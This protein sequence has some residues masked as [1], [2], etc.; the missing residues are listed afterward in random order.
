MAVLPTPSNYAAIWNLNPPSSTIPLQESA[1]A[2]GV[3]GPES[4]GVDRRTLV[5]YSDYA[6]GGE[7]R[8]IIK[9]FVCYERQPNDGNWGMATGWLIAPDLL[10]TAGHVAY[11]FGP[12]TQYGKAV[13]VKAYMGYTGAVNVTPTNLSRRNVQL[14][15]GATFITTT[16]WLQ[17]AGQAER[18][19]V[20][21][22]KL[23]G[24][25]TGNFRPFSYIDTP[26]SGVAVNIGVVGYP[27]DQQNSAGEAGAEMYQMIQSPVIRQSDNSVIG[28]HVFNEG[29]VNSA[30]DV[31]GRYG[32]MFGPFIRAF[33]EMD[34]PIG[35]ILNINVIKPLTAGPDTLNLTNIVNV[36]FSGG[37]T[38]SP[39]PGT[40][41]NGT[42]GSTTTPVTP[43]TPVV[44]VSPVLPVAPVVPGTTGTTG[45]TGSTSSTIAP[46]GGSTTTTSGTEGF[47]DVLKDIVK[48]SLPVIDTG[49]R[50][51]FPSVGPL[52]PCAAA[53]GG[54][55]LGAICEACESAFNSST[56][57]FQPASA[58]TA[59]SLNGCAQRAILAETAL[60][61]AFRLDSRE[62]QGQQIITDMANIY[63]TVQ[64]LEDLNMKLF[65]AI[66]GPIL[67]IALN[68]ITATPPTQ[69]AT[70]VK[71]PL[72]G[73]AAVESSFSS[74]INTSFAT[75]L[76]QP[77]I[78]VPGQESF[79]DNLSS[80]I[81]TGLQ[82]AT[83]ITT[84]LA[85]SAVKSALS[86]SPESAL[87]ATARDN[88]VSL[89]LFRRAI[90]AECALQAVQ[91]IDTTTLASLPLYDEQGNP[92]TEGF[93]D[94]MTKA[95]QTIGQKVLDA[96]PD[97]I[98]SVGPIV[99]SLVASAIQ[100]P[101][102]GGS[103]AASDLP[104]TAGVVSVQP[105]SIAALADSR[106][107]TSP[108]PAAETV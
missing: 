29:T 28:V 36:T 86:A 48:V 3:K 80:V 24:T 100:K 38:V 23:A 41:T 83:P 105:I 95:M 96:A 97:V 13:I 91:K 75:Q 93:F 66:A 84:T 62:P 56:R 40:D 18:A 58:P 16:G 81:S 50:I 1:F 87:E 60:Q 25:F 20:S 103:R 6:D 2:L 79:F 78:I 7:Y 37:V 52:S 26:L 9:L 35:N 21:F 59:D 22:L 33:S 42:G 43:V 17:S 44:P 53:I 67:R 77:T 15:Y 90:V 61:A 57:T 8:A 10:V 106:P 74:T 68:D 47:L 64:P 107:G 94:T 63:A 55:A 46:T 39:L 12:T 104:M 4:I 14:Q 102:G 70:Q 49:L 98:A 34:A 76:L 72:P 82:Y 19:D 92:T 32:N 101:S 54:V 51:L 31:N 30:S 85:Q 5:S 71:V 99:A 73:V 69:S 65:P 45:S 11:D 88:I 27:A 108:V 89:P